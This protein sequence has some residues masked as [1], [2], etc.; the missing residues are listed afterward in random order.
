LAAATTTLT[1]G[2]F[3]TGADVIC[4]SVKRSLRYD[5]FSVSA[6]IFITKSSIGAAQSAAQTLEEEIRKENQD[7]LISVGGTTFFDAAVSSNKAFA[8]RGDCNLDFEGP[9]GLKFS[10]S[11]EGRLP[12]QARSTGFYIFSMDFNQSQTERITATF[13]GVYT[14]VG[15]SGASA[16]YAD[17]T[18]GAEARCASLLNTYYNGRSFDMVSPKLSYPEESDNWIQFTLTYIERIMPNSA[19]DYDFSN[20]SF[21]RSQTSYAGDAFEGSGDVVGMNLAGTLMAPTAPVQ[22]WTISGFIPVKSTSKNYDDLMSEWEGAIKPAL[23]SFISTYFWAAALVKSQYSEAFIE[24]ENTPFDVTENGI[25]PNL[26]VV[27]PASGGIIEFS[28]ALTYNYDPRYVIEYLLNGKDD[29]KAWIGKLPTVISCVQN[30][31]CTKLTSYPDTLRPPATLPGFESVTK[32]IQDSPARLTHTSR[33]Y[34]ITDSYQRTIKA[35]TL[36]YTCNWKLVHID[37]YFAGGSEAS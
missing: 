15:A 26:S 27:L 8:V 9:T 25:N 32:W 29:L 5:S 1:Y 7:L 34:Q 37:S 13:S 4:T 28:E 24:N 16:L 14:A 10:I 30:A 21:T 11:F 2:S 36:E 31:R 18:N 17:N 33:N 20:I 19:T 35:K 22:R 6:E 23:W 3:T 12:A